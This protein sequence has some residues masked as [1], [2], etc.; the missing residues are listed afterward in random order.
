[1]LIQ[2]AGNTADFAN[3]VA[4]SDCREHT[5]ADDCLLVETNL[6]GCVSLAVNANGGF[7]GGKGPDVL[8][9]KGDARAKLPSSYWASDGP[10]SS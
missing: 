6:N 4:L 10:C 9:A 5:G 7:A 1:M 2:E 3:G 8:S